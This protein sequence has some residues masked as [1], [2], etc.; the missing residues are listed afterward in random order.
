M[1]V[2]GIDPGTAMLGYG[3]VDAS[4]REPYRLVECGILRTR[5]ANPCPPGSA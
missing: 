3:V 5:A 4:P 2:L 1:S